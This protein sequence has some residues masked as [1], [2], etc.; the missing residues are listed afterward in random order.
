MRNALPWCGSHPLGSEFTMVLSLVI[1]GGR[2]DLLRKL[3]IAVRKITSNM[4]ENQDS[5]SDR[6]SGDPM[7]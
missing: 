1:D 4:D 3:L 2:R 6:D 7:I 5:A